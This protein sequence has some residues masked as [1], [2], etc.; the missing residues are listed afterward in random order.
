MGKKLVILGHLDENGWMVCDGCG[1]KVVNHATTP[2]MLG[3]CK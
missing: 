1:E 2:G 3:F